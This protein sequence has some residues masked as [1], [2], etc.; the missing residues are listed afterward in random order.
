[1]LAASGPAACFDPTVLRPAGTGHHRPLPGVLETTFGSVGNVSCQHAQSRGVHFAT[2][3][4][5]MTLPTGAADDPLRPGQA[6][7]LIHPD[8][9]P[10]LG[11]R[12]ESLQA[13]SS[14]Y[15]HPV[16]DGAWQAGNLKAPGAAAGAGTELWDQAATE[17]PAAQRGRRGRSRT[18]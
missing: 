11:G 13:P 8:S 15:W 2:A 17:S 18:R 9:V 12:S 16:S 5:G 3:P 4:P 6:R 7:G 14:A 1:M 10:Q